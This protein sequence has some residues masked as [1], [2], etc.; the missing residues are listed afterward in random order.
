MVLFGAVMRLCVCGVWFCIVMFD[1]V[2]LWCL[3]LCNLLDCIVLMCGVCR[4]VM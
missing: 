3:Y 4:F 2:L 1:G